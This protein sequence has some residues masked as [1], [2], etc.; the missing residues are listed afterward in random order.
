MTAEYLILKA[1][2]KSD[3]DLEDRNELLENYK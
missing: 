2:A 3:F 1:V